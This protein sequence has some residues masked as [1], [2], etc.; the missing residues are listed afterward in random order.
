MKTTGKVAGALAVVVL[1]LLGYA[2]LFGFDPGQWRP[3]LWLRGEVVT[4]P[5]TDWTFAKDLGGPTAIQTRERLIP[6]L[7]YSITSSRF[8]HDGNLYLGSGYATGVKMPAGRHWNKNIL[9]DPA[10]RVRIDGK[11]YDGSLVYVDNPAEHAAV[12][13]AYERNFG[14]FWA[15]GYYIHLWR[16][17]PP[18]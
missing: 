18:A 3:G 4:T 5:V 9:A 17:E 2:R 8:I 6:G 15:P 7:V 10:V 14:I 11:L 1:L 13:K 12:I 16:L